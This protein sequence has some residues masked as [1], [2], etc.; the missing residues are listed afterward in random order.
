MKTVA[1]NE[2]ATAPV[3][4]DAPEPTPGP[5]Q[6]LVLVQASSVN[7]LDAGIAQGMF[8]DMVPHELPITLGRDFA[9]VVDA[10]GPGV[11]GVG[12]GDRV[13]GEVPMGAPVRDGAWAELIVIGEDIL[14]R[15]PDGTDTAT[16]GAVG[17]AATTA[18]MTVDALGLRPGQTVVVIGATG[19]VGSI[20]VQLAR[21]A[22]ATVLA[23]GR[24]E[25]E[26]YLRGLGVSEVLDGD[27]AAAVSGSYPEGVDALV[28]AVTSYRPTPYAEV[29]KDGGRI[30]SPTGAAGEGPGRTDV[31]HAPTA[32][33]LQRVAR[34]L[35]DGTIT[36]TIHQT[37]DL[38]QVA[39][40]L[41]ALIAGHI[42]GKI[43]LRVA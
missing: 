11:T 35:A 20:V 3:L 12:T 1:I 8:Q 41:Q 23:P 24:P 9:G 27:I 15:T 2:F 37:Y 7:W 18:V 25:D 14:T 29:V 17:L 42:R 40:A 5:G 6:V 36:V 34:H 4:G 26:E 38:A 30:A 39:E 31:M 33:I 13:F 10:V 28:D 19:G 16:A 43:A 32:D 21:A 22:G